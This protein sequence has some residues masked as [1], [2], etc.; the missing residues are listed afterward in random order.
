MKKIGVIT[1]NDFNNYGN[2][3]Q[4]YALQHFLETMGF[5]VENIYNTYNRDNVL[6]S[7]GKRMLRTLRNVG[8]TDHISARKANFQKFNERIHFSEETII[9]GQYCEDIDEKYDYFVTGSDQ[10]WNLCDCGRSEIDFLSFVSRE[11][12]IS[13]SASMGIQKIPDSLAEK[14]EQYLRDFKAI[15]VREE[16]GREMVEALTGRKDVEVL[17]D[18]TLLLTADEWG[19]LAEKPDHSGCDQYIVVYFLGRNPQWK[20]TIHGFA[21]ESGYKVV[22]IYDPNSAFYGC[23]PQHFL[24]WIQN[25]Q[26]I[27][28]DSFHCSV[29]AFLFNRPFVVFDRD[30]STMNMNARMDTFLE[31]FRLQE[32]RYITG[33]DLQGY[34]E[35]DY[36][37]GYQVLEQEREKARRFVA[38]ALSEKGTE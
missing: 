12:R 24:Y 32:N 37:T 27:C 19:Q 34:F 29:F 35:R 8:R 15:S 18:P 17:I 3:L 26:M 22:D 30:H 21:K 13:F 33:N 5:T 16:S 14:Y 31:K 6:V 2:R 36:S 25:A 4:C 1:I 10:V 7:C 28:T 23:G 38:R 9:N 20:D 11:K